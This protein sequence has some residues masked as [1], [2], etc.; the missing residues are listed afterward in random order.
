M[1][2]TILDTSS[3]INFDQLHKPKDEI[4]ITDNLSPS[5]SGGGGGGFP[6]L[7]T[8]VVQSDKLFDSNK[9]IIQEKEE[10]ISN[11][12]LVKTSKRNY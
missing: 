2:P 3:L 11:I 1:T 8:V 12:P 6:T 7:P 9:I 5:S 10:I 4:I